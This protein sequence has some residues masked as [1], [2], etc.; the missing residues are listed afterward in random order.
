[1]G[2]DE[3]SKYTD[4]LRQASQDTLTAKF[5]EIDEGH[6]RPTRQPKKQQERRQTIETNIGKAG[7]LAAPQKSGMGGGGGPPHD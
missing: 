2:G 4:G 7:K 1:M 6:D 5:Q 3:I